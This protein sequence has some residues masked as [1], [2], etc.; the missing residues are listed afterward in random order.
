MKI[1]PYDNSLMTAQKQTIIVGANS[2]RPKQRLGL[3]A[4]RPDSQGRRTE[5]EK[6]QKQCH[7]CYFCNLSLVNLSDNQLVLFKNKVT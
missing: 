1:S 3:Y 4:I 2:I 7:F 6:H 5:R